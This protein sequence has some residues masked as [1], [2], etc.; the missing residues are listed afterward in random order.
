[1]TLLDMIPLGKEN[2]IK[3]RE[4]CMMSG[5]NDRAMREAISQLRR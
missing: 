5:L 4:L 1:M 3:R 2:A